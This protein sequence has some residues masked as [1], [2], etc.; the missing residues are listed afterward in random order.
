MVDLLRTVAELGG[1]AKTVELLQ[2]GATKKGLTAAVRTG[3]LLRP[4]KAW[5]VLPQTP[6][7][8]LEAVRV[9]GR[10]TCVTALAY[11][12]VW[13]TDRPDRVHVAV[14]R[15][16]CQLRSTA[17]PDERQSVVED[18]IVHWVDT[19]RPRHAPYSRLVEPPARALT[20]A[21]G[22]LRGEALL[23]TVESVLHL[24]LVD[25]LT[26][27]ELLASLP[28]ATR[29][30]LADASDLSASGLETYFVSGMRRLG[31]PVRQQ[32]WIGVDR[33][34]TLLGD[35]LVVE[36]D[37]RAFHDPRA[38]HDR[39][40]RLILEGMHVLHFDYHQVL[41]DW[42][43]VEAVVRASLRRGDHMR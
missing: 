32:V 7:P 37:G 11:F 33:V 3:V 18:A 27:Q 23:A 10:A 28:A 22:C 4:R 39:D 16:A 13:L 8:L 43:T 40:A 29:R 41:H 30:E 2:A 25:D 6:R 19:P 15:A 5:Y 1:A 12:G 20:D 17:R 24:G 35:C 31:I 14:H 36:L 21:M 9:G 42:A 38:D 34:D 26:W